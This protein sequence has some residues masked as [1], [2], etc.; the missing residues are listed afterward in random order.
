MT[1]SGALRV[2]AIV[3]PTASGKTDLAIEVSEAVGG[4]I[5][6]ADS[7][8][9]Y[10]HLDIGTAKPNAAER[11]RVRHHLIDVVDP[12]EAFDAARYRTL[13]LGAA[14]D[15]HARGRAVVICGGTGLYVRA[16]LHG[17]FVGPAASPA[18]RA[19]LRALEEQEGTGTLH[20]RLAARDPVAAARL[21]PRDVF[22]IVRALEVVEM[23]GRPI[24]AWQDD[25]R[26]GDAALDALLVACARPR[27]E[28]AARIDARCRAMV[29]AGLCDEIAALAARGYGPHLAPLRSVGYREMGAHLRGELD[30][31]TAFEAFARATRQLAKRQ[32]TW[33][34][35]DPTT[36]WLHPE[37]DRAAVLTLATTWLDKPCPA[38][39][40]TSSSPS[41]L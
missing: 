13:A 15:I 6:S 40:S 24:S 3:G 22:R 4:E 1:A 41:R 20:R 5:V 16:L 26:F 34:R 37:R 12:D 36:R 17:L 8:Q 19:E 10:R 27:D 21:H 7:R 31:T 2:V 35:A 25:H 33:F 29:A 28:L 9:I 38:P 30:F 11:A 39:I 23:S 14:R 18:L 32:R